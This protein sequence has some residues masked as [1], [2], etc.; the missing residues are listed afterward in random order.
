MRRHRVITT[1]ALLALAL[2]LP[3]TAHAG[4]LLSGYGGPGQG[5]QAILGATVIGGASGGGSAGGGGSSSGG[6]SSATSATSAASPATSTPSSRGSAHQP[7]K[8]K[9]RQ[10]HASAPPSGAHRAASTLSLKDTASVATPAL[11]I[12]GTD[13]LYVLLALGALIL[14]AAITGWLVR[15]PGQDGQSAKGM[16]R[17]TRVVN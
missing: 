17:R 11:G 16:R 12:S 15:R 5:N 6:E 13:L 4:S 8:A 14:T 3:A 9:P 7:G 1:A 10:G 2:A